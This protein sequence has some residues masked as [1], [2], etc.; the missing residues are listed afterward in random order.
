MAFGCGG[1]STAPATGNPPGTVTATA[2]TGVSA[3]ALS[4]SSIRVSF[5]SR[6]GDN[7]YTVERAEGSSG[8]FAPIGV[9]TAPASAATLSFTDANLKTNTLYRYRVL[10]VLGN[11]TSAPSSEASATTLAALFG[12]ADITGDI[13]ANRTLYAETTYTIK[14]FIH[15]TNGATL[16]IRPGTTIK[17]DYNTLGSSLFIMRGA[18]IQAL[19]TADAPIVFTS[20]RAAGQRQPGDW[21]GLILVG[22]ALQNRSGSVALEGTGTDGSGVVSGKNYQVLYSGGTTA[23]GQFRNHELRPRG[24]RRLR[25]VVGQ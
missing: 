10:T 19:G 4:L 23:V 18:K 13:T 5:T 3:V 8:S 1:D 6:A 20:S 22:N 25:A 21:G 17:G 12:V 24:V 9:I 15:V 11:S 16:T 7:S 2:V 14:G